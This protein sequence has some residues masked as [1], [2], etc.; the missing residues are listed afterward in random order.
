[1]IQNFKDSGPHALVK[2]KSLSN[3]LGKNFTDGPGIALFSHQLKH[4]LSVLF[5]LFFVENIRFILVF[6][7]CLSRFGPMFSTGLCAYWGRCLVIYL[8]ISHTAEFSFLKNFFATPHGIQDLC[9]PTRD[10]TCALHSRSMETTRL[11]GK[12]KQ[13]VWNCVGTK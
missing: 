6:I 12:F 13:S 5:I 4:F 3:L 9:Y 8:F 2:S 11:P 7:V 10:Q 1:M